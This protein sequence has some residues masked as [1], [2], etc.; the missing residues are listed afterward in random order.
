MYNDVKFINSAPVNK[1]LPRDL[2]ILSQTQDVFESLFGIHLL[3]IRDRF[4][5]LRR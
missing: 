1:N 5:T 3:H 4:T 2:V